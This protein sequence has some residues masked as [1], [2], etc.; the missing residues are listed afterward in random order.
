MIPVPDT[1][2]LAEPCWWYM[3]MPR[4]NGQ[5]YL[6][7]K[8][9][10]GD[11][12]RFMEDT[13]TLVYKHTSRASS[14]DEQLISFRPGVSGVLYLLGGQAASATQFYVTDS[15]HHFIRGAVYFNTVPNAD[16][17]A[18]VQEYIRED[19]LRMLKTLEWK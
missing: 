5:V 19:I 7:Y 12:A 13:H 6:T 10:N 1:N 4:L 3:V 14:I 11:V 18:P 8:S 17:L 9:L 15:V 2:G 16:S